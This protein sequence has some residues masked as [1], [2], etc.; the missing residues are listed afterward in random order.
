MKYFILLLV[1]IGLVSCDS[2]AQ[3]EAKIKA[4]KNG[5]LS[6]SG[7]SGDSF[8]HFRFNSTQ[9][10]AKIAKVAKPSELKVYYVESKEN[11]IEPVYVMVD[12]DFEAAKKDESVLKAWKLEGDSLKIIYDD[13][14]EIE[15]TWYVA[16]TAFKSGNN[17]I[18]CKASYKDKVKDLGST[19]ADALYSQVKEK[20]AVITVLVAP[21]S[22]DS[23][24]VEKICEKAAEQ[25]G[26]GREHYAAGFKRNI[27]AFKKIESLT[28][29]RL[30]KRDLKVKAVLK[31]AALAD[32]AEKVFNGKPGK[33]GEF[34][35]LNNLKLLINTLSN[36]S[37]KREG[38]NLS[39][40]LKPKSKYFGIGSLLREAVRYYH[41]EL[42]PAK[43]KVE[44]K[45]STKPLYEVGNY[46]EEELI[47][48]V[49]EKLKFKEIEERGYKG[50]MWNL[51]MPNV[52]LG[53]LKVEAVKAVDKEGKEV[54]F[55][56]SFSSIVFRPAK[57]QVIEEVTLKV[58]LDIPLQGD[59]FEFKPGEDGTVKTG[60]F[61]A[62]KLIKLE[63][64]L[65]YLVR[66]GGFYSEVQAL[67]ETGKALE[68]KRDK[69]STQ[70]G[71]KVHGKVARVKL[72]INS[73][74]HA[75]EYETV[76]KFEQK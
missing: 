18:V 44:T 15:K 51:S 41:F 53:G 22:P 45:Y 10:Y 67:D 66:Q 20:E 48:T 12:A 76:Y 9:L 62:A 50:L 34:S 68:F 19:Y 70:F 40:V 3:V 74:P 75:C 24:N 30:P 16:D 36:V 23:V 60:K 64:D 1:T 7:Q 61:S 65:F 69:G 54:K 58:K 43:E 25:F 21:E 46:T 63:N 47:K 49:K 26:F 39:A 38:L 28:V 31:D 8:E 73:L 11:G 71:K 13:L 52:S 55:N 57:E 4:P 32:A 2:N 35:K 33:L 17:I 5:V 59:V 27:D 37:I 72:L 6:L 14:R 42:T 56:N 29:V